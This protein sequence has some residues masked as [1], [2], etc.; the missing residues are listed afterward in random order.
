MP[1][2]KKE[3]ISGKQAD[4]SLTKNYIEQN[5]EVLRDMKKEARNKEH[6]S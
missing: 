3:K 2:I 4:G 1:S 6:D 5:R